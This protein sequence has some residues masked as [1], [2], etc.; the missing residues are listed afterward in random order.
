VLFRSPGSKKY[1]FDTPTDKIWQT[2][3]KDMGGK[4]ASLSMIP[5]DLSLN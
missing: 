1:I 5:E 2:V 4:Y 3:L